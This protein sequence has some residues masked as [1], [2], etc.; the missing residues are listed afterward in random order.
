MMKPLMNWTFLFLAITITLTISCST[1]KK[2]TTTSPTDPGE[3]PTLM[4]TIVVT[5]GMNENDEEEFLPPYQPARQR[6]W[7]LMHTALDISFDWA[8]QNVIGVATLK[9]TPLFYPQQ[10]LAL[11]ADH[12]KVKKVELFGRAYNDYANDSSQI[13][14]RL[15]RPYKKGEEV[16]VTVYYEAHPKGSLA[17]DATAILSD[18]GL[19]FIDPLDT[20]PDLP[21]QIWTQGETSSSRKWFPTLDQPNERTTQEI[22]LTVPDSMMTLSNGI[23]VSSTPLGNGMKKDYWKMDLSHAPYL[24]MI[25]VGQWDKA[26]DY[27]RGRPLDYYVDRGYGKDARAIFANTGEMMEFFSTKL[28][29]AYVWPKY[30]QVIVRNFVSGAM[31]NTTATVFGEFIQFHK[32]DMLVDG[33]NDYIV[34][35][36]LFHHWFG[37][38]VTCESWSNIVLNEGFANYG[39]YLWS[40][41]KYG[42]EKADISRMQE[43]SGYYYQS[44]YDAHALFHPHYVSEESLFDAHAYNKG[45]LVLHMLRDL[46]G[47]DA[48]YASLHHYLQEHE[49]SAVEVDDLRQAFEATT[50]LDLNWFFNQWYLGKGHPVIQVEQQYN[51]AGNQ[52]TLTFRQ[53]QGEEK[54]FTDFFRLP[55]DVMIINRDSTII[56]KKIWLEQ[57]TQSFTFDVA[58]HPLTVILDPRDILLA[59]VQHD[60]PESEYAIR[61]LL[62]PS[63]SHR[64]S[65][66]RL[67]QDMDDAYLNRIMHD[68]SWTARGMAIQYLVDHEDAG[69][70]KEMAMR[71]TDIEL[72]YVILESLMNLDPVKAKEVAVHFLKTASRAPMIYAALKAVAAADVDEAVTQLARFENAEWDAVYAV[73]ASIY[74][75]KGGLL[76]LDYFKT[77]QAAAIHE[78]YLEELIGAMLNYLATQPASVQEEGLALIRSDFFL[79]KSSDYR[80]YFLINSLVL[81]YNEE[82]NS[83]FKTKLHDAIRGLYIKIEDDY[84]KSIVKE[85]L[86][87]LVD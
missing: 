16:T 79:G 75:K 8:K 48:F 40:E 50:G 39:E 38:L 51:D 44:E 24:T 4:D 62:A 73:R 83:A 31:E 82:T 46:V 2:A 34:A 15:P 29:Y 76:T 59:V 85:G 30:A 33:S 77:P 55:L 61:G 42:R 3:E 49:F 60:V 71:E 43:L 7:D 56:N 32:E 27:W 25:A 41:Y 28:N 84:I 54:G 17:E 10:T 20:I 1:S 58:P 35:H 67:M 81:Q 70:L 19:F 78:N 45:G 12:F 52:L 13:I 26:T 74:E 14:F 6:H 63:V 18:Q 86:G 47:D 23:L 53:T 68:P 5:E 64:L 57:K 66:L 69:R 21:R 72:Q 22:T 87:D 65:A 9:L 80:T 11:D 36:E 37:D